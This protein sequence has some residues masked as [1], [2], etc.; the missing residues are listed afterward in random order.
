M[1]MEAH[2]CL[3]RLLNLLIIIFLRKPTGG[4][5]PIG[6]FPGLIRLWGRVRRQHV[7]EWQATL[8]RDFLLGG[9]R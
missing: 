2:L 8:K 5:R 4:F 3:P 9:R 1:Y 7:R 6:L